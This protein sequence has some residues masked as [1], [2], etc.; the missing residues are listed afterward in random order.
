[1]RD[2]IRIRNVSFHGY[3][4]VYEW[5]QKQGQRF[6]FSARLFVDMEKAGKTDGLE[7]TVNY[8]SVLKHILEFLENNRFQ[9]LEKV[10]T[11]ALEDTMQAFPLI[12]EMELELEKP[13]API[14]ADFETVS[15]CRSL[16]RARAYIALGSN[17]GDKK[18]YIEA[19]LRRID[20]HPCC[21][22]K[23]VS[24]LIETKPYGGV[25]QD[26]FLNGAA[27]VE[28]LLS[29]RALLDFLHELEQEAGRVRE[30]V[31]GPR[32]LDLDILLYDD[33]VMDSEDLAIPHYD[34]ERR[35]FVLA[36]MAEIAPFLR[37]PISGKT[38]REMLMDSQEPELHS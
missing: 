25:E 2:Q 36:P 16:K 11:R 37:H 30:V 29:P 22:V 12:N 31:W 32:T 26:D 35:E 8:G 20:E 27:C 23:K 38:M 24:S 7:D 1:M 6:I 21:S 17:M 34:M 5:E 18:G 3:H 14:E 15:V 4:G 19:A 13:D 33:L 9:L 28:T 10:V